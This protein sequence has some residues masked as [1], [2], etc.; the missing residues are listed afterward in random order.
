MKSSPTGSHLLPSLCS[1][2]P[3]CLRLLLHYAL[4]RVRSQMESSSSLC[5]T[6]WHSKRLPDERVNCFPPSLS[7]RAVI[8]ATPSSSLKNRTPYS[9][10]LHNQAKGK[11]GCSL[12]PPPDLG[13]TQGLLGLREHQVEEL[14]LFWGS[15]SRTTP[16]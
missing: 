8:F 11:P 2:C 16:G 5:P 4:R 10:S 3:L 7:P 9:V 1:G 15:D 13:S 6:A 12:P 14:L